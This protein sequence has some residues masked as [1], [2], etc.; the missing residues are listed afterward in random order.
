[1]PYICARSNM[2]GA[3]A[4][5]RPPWRTTRMLSCCAFAEGVPPHPH[6]LVA[7]ERMRDRGAI[8]R[9]VPLPF[10]GQERGLIGD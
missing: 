4:H 7:K 5:T 9:V 2:S 3:I 6:P 1:M 10:E 8:D